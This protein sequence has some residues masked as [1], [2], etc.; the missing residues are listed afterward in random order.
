MR[1]LAAAVVVLLIGSCGP[2][3]G[4]TTDTASPRSTPRATGTP[5]ISRAGSPTPGSIPST[6]TAAATPPS[7]TDPEEHTRPTATPALD[8][9]GGAGSLAMPYLRRDHTRL[10]VEVTAVEDR[11]PTPRVR[12]LLGARLRDVLDKPGGVDVLDPR[13]IPPQGARHDIEG[14]W[15]SRTGRP[16]W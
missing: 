5:Q 6:P 11:A 14:P 2:S 8:D 15:G 4:P 13:I 16:R 1:R 3:D 10:V 7:T 9:Y 12:D